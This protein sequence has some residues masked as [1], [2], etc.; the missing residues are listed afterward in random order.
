LWEHK[1]K[2]DEL[3]VSVVVVTFQSSATAITNSDHVPADWPIMI[4]ERRHLYNYFQMARA[5]FWDLWGPA[6]WNAYWQQ[7]LK[8]NVPRRIAGD[9]H[10]QG[11]D[12][13]IDRRGE[14]TMLHVG[15]GPADRPTVESIL[16]IVMRSDTLS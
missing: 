7:L 14:I 5:S 2:F 13:L 6:T 4:D 8:G 10:Q 1:Q 15:A 3:G 16:D 9:I 12:V 11:G